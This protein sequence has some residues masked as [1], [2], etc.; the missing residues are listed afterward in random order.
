MRV[1]QLTQILPTVPLLCFCCRC[2]V[3]KSCLTLCD[4]VDCSTPGFPVLH[5]LPEFA[6]TH[7]HC[8]EGN[9]NPLHC[10]S[11][12][13]PEMVEPGGLPSMGS[14]RVGHEWSDLAAAAAA[15]PLSQWCHPTISPSVAPF[16][17]CPKSFPI[18]GSFPMSQLFASGGQSIGT[19]I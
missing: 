7:V 14:H 13:I 15:C 17:S 12:R 16:F 4:A 5:Y 11:W 6:Q 8:G 2:S 18:S 3:T 10:S 19:S 1:L 9:D